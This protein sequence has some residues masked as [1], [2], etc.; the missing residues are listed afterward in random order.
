M[1]NFI[2]TA[3]EIINEMSATFAQVEGATVDGRSIYFHAYG[4]ENGAWGARVRRYFRA[5]G[6]KVETT[7]VKKEDGFVTL[8]VREA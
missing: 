3:S 5:N 6:L 8:E 4:A 2:N 1:H 7:Y